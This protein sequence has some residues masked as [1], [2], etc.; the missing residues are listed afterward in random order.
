MTKC[1]W[2]P[3]HLNKDQTAHVSDYFDSR[4]L[5]QENNGQKEKFAFFRGFP[6]VGKELNL[7]ENY[8]SILVGINE[9]K[10]VYK[11]SDLGTVNVWDL[12]PQLLENAIGFTDLIKAAEIL[13]EE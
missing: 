9:N 11:K 2:I 3:I 6:L 8:Q 7:P 1:D 12:Q 5:E 4:I 13:A 10:H